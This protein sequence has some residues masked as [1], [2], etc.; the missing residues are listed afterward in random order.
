VHVSVPRERVGNRGALT[1][2][3]P[4]DG[5]VMFVLPAGAHTIVGT[6][7][8]PTASAPDDVRASEEDVAYLLRSANAFF[9]DARLTRSDVVSA[10][11]GIRPLI[12]AGYKHGA[13]NGGAAAAAASSASREHHIERSPS[14]VVTV[15]GGKLTTYRSM[16]AEVVD[17]VERALGRERPT[18]SRTATLPLPG[19]DLGSYDAELSAARRAIGDAAPPAA[20]V[21]LVRAHGSRWRD[22]WALAEDAPALT[23]PL[24]P[25]LPYL[26]AELTYAV[27]H[28]TACT[29]TDL[30]VRRTHV[31]FETPDNGRAAARLA[32]D[33]V[34]PLLGWDDAA[35]AAALSE[36]EREAARIFGVDG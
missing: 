7:E 29:L 16:A 36:Y 33:V 14:G 20:A 28:E 6:T 25:G 4:L 35:R 19:G 21:R 27:E 18:P 30:L 22:V 17:E 10:W 15:S 26:R 2:L 3:S 11:A 32:A 5:R 9:P 1:L 12:A 23:A 31:A 34:A 8:T 13:T 24:V